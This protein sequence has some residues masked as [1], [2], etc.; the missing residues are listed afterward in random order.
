MGI[1]T[2]M[3]A[4]YDDEFHHA[5]ARWDDKYDDNVIDPSTMYTN[6]ALDAAELDPTTGLGIEVGLK[7]EQPSN[8]VDD[9]RSDIPTWTMDRLMDPEPLDKSIG[10]TNRVRGH[11]F[12][13]DIKDPYFPSQMAKDLGI[14]DMDK[15]TVEEIAAMTVK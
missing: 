3:G 10:G 15:L 1:G 2:S 7:Y 12:L 6:K 9:R 4:Y 13:S 14:D 5:A 8:N 11:G